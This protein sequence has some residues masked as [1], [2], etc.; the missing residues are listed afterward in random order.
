MRYHQELDNIRAHVNSLRLVIV[1]L[2]AVVGVMG[3]GWQS[4]PTF[5]RVYHPPDL[6]S[7]AVLRV[8]EVPPSVV[9]NFT[10]Y[11]LQQL[12]NWPENGDQDYG[13]QIY[14]LAAYL[15]PA[16]RENRIV[17]METRGRRGEL[18]YRQRRVQ[19]PPGAGYEERRVD[20]L[21]ADSWV[22]W[23]DLEIRETVRGMDV[24]ETTVRYPVRVVRFEVD[25]EANPWGLALDGWA[26]PGPE[27]LSDEDT[28]LTL[29]V[30]P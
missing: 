17:D 14:R 4:A 25:P 3:W 30:Q 27:R 6:R 23:V 5:I 13:V 8:G 21:D 9:W 24:K 12:N 22:V 18:Q 11:I 29:E 20:V 26:D 15:T 16:F 1:A 7:G 10:Q 28:S 19:M 2:L